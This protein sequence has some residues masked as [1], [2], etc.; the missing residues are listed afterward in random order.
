MWSE[1]EGWRQALQANITILLRRL[2]WATLLLWAGVLGGV[3][4]G[5]PAAALVL[6]VAALVGL[7]AWLRLSSRF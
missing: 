7:L 2:L 4:L 3:I 5:A 1:L 6:P